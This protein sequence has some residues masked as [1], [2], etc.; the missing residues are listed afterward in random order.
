MRSICGFRS[1][2]ALARAIQVPT[3]TAY[4]RLRALQDAG[5]PV[6]VEAMAMPREA[7]SH[8]KRSPRSILG[9]A[10]ISTAARKLGISYATLY[11]RVCVAKREARPLTKR[12]LVTEYVDGTRRLGLQERRR[13]A[14][15]V[16]ECGRLI[17]QALRRAA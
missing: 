15:V 11:D 14:L 4:K 12:V 16:R 13:R 6:T 9:Y 17:E 10:S 7:I 3:S 1:V 8:A 2:A 5:V